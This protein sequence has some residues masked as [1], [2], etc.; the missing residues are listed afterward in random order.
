MLPPHNHRF[1]SI[2][3]NIESF[4]NQDFHRCDGWYP[5]VSAIKQ[6]E[7]RMSDPLPDRLR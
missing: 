3:N 1:R 6:S 7:K 5:S 4:S 2:V